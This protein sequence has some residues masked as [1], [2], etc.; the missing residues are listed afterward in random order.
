MHPRK[1]LRQA[2]ALRE[3]YP[4]FGPPVVAGAAAAM[5]AGVICLLGLGAGRTLVLPP[6][7]A[8]AV[9]LIDGL[10]LDVAD[11]D[12]A[13]VLTVALVLVVIAA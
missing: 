5:G 8:G 6:V 7:V 9:F 4:F 11:V 2:A 12:P 1:P 13:V 3:A 10:L